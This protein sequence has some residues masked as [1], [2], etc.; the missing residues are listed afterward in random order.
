MLVKNIMVTKLT[1]AYID[2]HVCDAL[3]RMRQEN[4]RMLPIVTEDNVVAGVFSTFSVMAHVV[5]D[6]ITSGDLQQVTYAPDMGILRRHY[7]KMA[8]KSIGAVM[9]KNPL[10]V[11]GK[12]SLLSVAAALTAYGKHEYAIVVDEQ[13]HLSGVISAGDILDRL[14]CI[15]KEGDVN[16]A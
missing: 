6:Y 7:N 8:H 9:D 15:L 2:E 13:Q 4:L 1:T 12:D 16:D 10:L 14:R 11:H 5:P 3:D